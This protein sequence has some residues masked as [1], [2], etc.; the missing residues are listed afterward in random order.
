MTDFEIDYCLSMVK[1]ATENIE[2]Y[3]ERIAENSKR[4]CEV[5]TFMS[6]QLKLDEDIISGVLHLKE[7][8]E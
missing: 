8:A 7:G 4:L 5:T 6:K 3:V 1:S 2:F